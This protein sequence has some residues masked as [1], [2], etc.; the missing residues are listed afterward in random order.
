MD[1]VLPNAAAGELAGRSSCGQQNKQQGGKPCL[2]DAD[3]I[4]AATKSF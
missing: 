3:L 4:A 2:K 1:A